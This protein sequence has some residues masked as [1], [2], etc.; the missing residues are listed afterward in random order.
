MVFI[1]HVLDYTL[2]PHHRI[3][4]FLFQFEQFYLSVQHLPQLLYGFQFGLEGGLFLETV[5]CKFH[6][7][8]F[9]GVVFFLLLYDKRIE[10][11]DF[12]VVSKFVVG[13]G[14]FGHIFFEKKI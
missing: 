11:E 13:K 2:L 6:V 12:S 8:F 7:G 14:K 9:H 4:I 1:K 10:G 3:H 5:N